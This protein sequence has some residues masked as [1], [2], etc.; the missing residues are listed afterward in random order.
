M[1]DPFVYIMTIKTL[2][3]DKIVGLVFELTKFLLGF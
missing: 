2:I 1:F 3:V